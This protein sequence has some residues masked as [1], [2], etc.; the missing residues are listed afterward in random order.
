MVRT[1]LSPKIYV[2]LFFLVVQKLCLYLMRKYLLRFL[3]EL[4]FH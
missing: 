4:L 1:I 3:K 2:I